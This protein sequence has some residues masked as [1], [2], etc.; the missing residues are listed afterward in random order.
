LAKKK[1]TQSDRGKIIVLGFLTSIF[2]NFVR[3]GQG[4][5]ALQP[6][7]QDPIPYRASTN[8]T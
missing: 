3:L 4:S 7:E 2:V 1:W 6:S 8:S 5:T